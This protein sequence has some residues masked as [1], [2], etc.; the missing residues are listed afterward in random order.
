MK[1]LMFLSTLLFAIV[2]T[3]CSNNQNSGG[4]DKPVQ[5]IKRLTCSQKVQTV[6]DVNMIADFNDSGLAYLGFEYKMELGSYTDEQIKAIGAVD[7]CGTV[8]ATLGTLKDAFTNCKQSV[9]NKALNITADFDLNKLVG[10]DISKTTSI[11]T[12]KEQLEK[13]NYSCTISN[14]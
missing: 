6:V 14:K 4:N 8:K 7:M 9:E 2:L 13:Q 10:S 11:D 12:A 5:V 3:G 1:K